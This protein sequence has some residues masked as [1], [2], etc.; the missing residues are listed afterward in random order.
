MKDV[1]VIIKGKRVRVLKELLDCQY[2]ELSKR[3]L[4]CIANDDKATAYYYDVQRQSIFNVLYYLDKA[5]EN[6]N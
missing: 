4:D 2:S 5:I 1:N 3:W 6:D